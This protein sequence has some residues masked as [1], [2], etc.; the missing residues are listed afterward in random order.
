MNARL[1]A[2]VAVAVAAA[3]GEAGTAAEGVAADVEGAAGAEGAAAVD[4]VAVEVVGAEGAAGA[5]DAAATAKS[6]SAE[7]ARTRFE[8]PL[9]MEGLELL[10]EHV[11]D[12]VLAYPRRARG[13]LDFA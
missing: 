1:E 3:S 11:D 5:E 12:G 10:G 9:H 6:L 2:V 7:I 13:S 4:M 8:A